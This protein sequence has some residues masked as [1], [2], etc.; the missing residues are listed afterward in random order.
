MRTCTTLS[1]PWRFAT[2]FREQLVTLYRRALA[3]LCAVVKCS[4]SAPTSFPFLRIVRDGKAENINGN[5]IH[6]HRRV[7]QTKTQ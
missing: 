7:I 3:T 5:K 1:K 6:C 2:L 4:D